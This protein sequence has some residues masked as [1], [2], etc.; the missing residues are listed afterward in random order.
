M[1]VVFCVSLSLNLLSYYMSPRRELLVGGRLLFKIRD[2]RNL[3]TFLD[4]V[5]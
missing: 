3:E 4:Q 2:N 1:P 5:T